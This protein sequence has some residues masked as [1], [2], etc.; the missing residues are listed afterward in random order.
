MANFH[1]SK[2]ISKHLPEH[3]LS[4]STHIKKLLISYKFTNKGKFVFLYQVTAACHRI[5]S[6]EIIMFNLN[7]SNHLL[8]F[9]SHNPMNSNSIFICRGIVGHISEWKSAE[10]LEKLVLIEFE[11]ILRHF[12]RNKCYWNRRLFVKHRLQSIFIFSQI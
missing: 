8:Q 6:K 9:I 7:Y 11:N 10:R 3:G 1:N 4:I 12:T 2:L 5:I